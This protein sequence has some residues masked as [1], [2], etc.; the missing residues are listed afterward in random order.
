MSDE[1]SLFER[2]EFMIFQTNRV[3]LRVEKF[4][5]GV[6]STFSKVGVSTSMFMRVLRYRNKYII[7]LKNIKVQM[8]QEKKKYWEK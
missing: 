2:S 7:S 4:E 3:F 8:T 6:L 1:K 5:L